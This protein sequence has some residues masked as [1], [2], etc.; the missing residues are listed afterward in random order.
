MTT[1]QHTVKAYDE[2]LHFIGSRLAEMG[3]IAEKMLYDA[4]D[5]LSRLDADLARRTIERD[6]KLDALQR[7][8]E[9]KAVLTIARRQ[10]MAVDLRELVAAIHIASDLERVGDLCKNIAKRTAKISGD[11]RVPRT[12]VGL[13]HMADIAAIQLKNVLDAYAQ[14]NVAQAD[15]VWRRDADVDALE[16]SVFRDL[17]TF[18]MED[19]RNISFCTHLLFCSKN[20][21]RIGDHATNI[22]ETVHYLVTGEPLPVERPKGGSS[23]LE[24]QA[25]AAK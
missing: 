2:E 22:A 15:E 4:I 21:E 1:D 13:K 18:M 6:P 3:G 7:E 14:K 24:P 8:I 20:I 19:P 25:A 10:P 23:G 9:E 12:L 11:M 17:L 5:A 16:D